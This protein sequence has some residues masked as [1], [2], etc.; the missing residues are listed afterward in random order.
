MKNKVSQLLLHLSCV[1]INLYAESPKEIELL[2]L[3]H[4]FIPFSLFACKG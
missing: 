2:L 4:I 3:P 1:Y